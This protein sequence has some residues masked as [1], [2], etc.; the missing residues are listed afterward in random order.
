MSQLG[1]QQWR[2]GLMVQGHAFAVTNLVIEP[3]M[4]YITVDLTRV[5]R[6]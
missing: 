1:M 2:K 3:A 4:R 5:Y 6:R